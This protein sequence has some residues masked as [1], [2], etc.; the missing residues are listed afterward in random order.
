MNLQ[1]DGWGN[2][3]PIQIPQNP[4]NALA[5]GGI[6]FFSGNPNGSVTVSG[7]ALGFDVVGDVFYFTANGTSWT[8]LS[9]GGGSAVTQLLA[10]T[11][12]TLS[13]SGGTGAVTINSTGGG[14]GTQVFSG[15]GNPNG[16]VTATAPALYYDT[17]SQ[18]IYQKTG[19][20]SSGW[21]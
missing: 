4:P 10:G 2:F 19:S 20:G 21:N 14:G 3:T 5:T 8:A 9:G 18:I 7:Q 16:V 17:V 13:P 11:N 6:V 1:R 12:I 15:S